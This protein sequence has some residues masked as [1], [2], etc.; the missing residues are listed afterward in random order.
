[1]SVLNSILRAAFDTL[2]LPFR[3][4]HPPFGLAF[5]S[6]LAAPLA[7]FVPL[8]AL[9]GVLVVVAWNM[10]E[11]KEAVHLLLKWRTALIL[12]AT[13]ATTLLKD[14]AWGVAVGCA[15]AVVLALVD[16]RATSTR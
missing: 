11:K 16:R 14:L 12:I 7:R 1:M 13:L 10:V 2:L 8:T 5:V 4:L 3:G 6:L 15:I 9:A